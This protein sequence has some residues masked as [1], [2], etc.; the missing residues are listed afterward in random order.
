MKSA[1]REQAQ[2]PR[3]KVV[4]MVEKDFGKNWRKIKQVVKEYA[5]DDKPQTKKTFE[6]DTAP[7]MGLRIKIPEELSLPIF[8]VEAILVCPCRHQRNSN[9]TYVMGI[10][11]DPRWPDKLF[12]GV[13]LNDE[14]AVTWY[15]TGVVIDY[16]T[17]EPELDKFRVVSDKMVSALLA[18]E[19]AQV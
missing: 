4:S 14:D 6:R 8:T 18:R 11:D 5:T 10:V 3:K 16:L 13:A 12:Y 15:E 1:G 2:T 19:L 9:I 7:L 17:I